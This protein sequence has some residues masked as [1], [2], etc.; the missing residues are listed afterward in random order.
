MDGCGTFR[1]YQKAHSPGDRGDGARREGGG[2]DYSG[3]DSIPDVALRTAA[4][5]SPGL[6]T[7]VRS[8]G[9]A[10]TLAVAASL[11]DDVDM[12][13]VRG[14]GGPVAAPLTADHRYRTSGIP[15]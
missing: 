6:V 13:R 3:A 7:Y 14:T 11:D 5:A 4:S 10:K 8:Q 2:W 12:V 1:L 15:A 9:H